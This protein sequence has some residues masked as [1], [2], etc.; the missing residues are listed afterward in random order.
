[1][2]Q[3]KKK[4]FPPGEVI[5]ANVLGNSPCLFALFCAV[6]PRLSFADDAP[7]QGRLHQP[8]QVRRGALH[9]GRLDEGEPTAA[10]FSSKKSRPVPVV[11]PPFPVCV[12]TAAFQCLKGRG[13]SPLRLLRRLSSDV[14][15]L[16]AL[17][18]GR[19]LAGTE[20]A[21]L[22]RLCSACPLAVG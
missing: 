22:R 13:R 12:F 7:T 18:C 19:D 6:S 17:L 15:R 14:C 11:S 4:R 10:C 2:Q 5:R 1:M 21:E 16:F 20:S 9:R 8:H 3:W